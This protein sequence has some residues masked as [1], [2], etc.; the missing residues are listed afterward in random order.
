MI[1]IKDVL[2]FVVGVTWD[3]RLTGAVVAPVNFT[4]FIGVH[5]LWNIKECC[6]ICNKKRQNK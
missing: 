6:K 3:L 2:D 1:R 5:T 4:D